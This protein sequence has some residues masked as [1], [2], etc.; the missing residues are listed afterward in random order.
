MSEPCHEKTYDNEQVIRRM[1]SEQKD[2]KIPSE[3]NPR[4]P[5]CGKPMT[6]NLRADDKFVQDDGWYDACARYEEFIETHKNQRVL[7]LELGVG[8]NTPVI[9][10][11]PFWRFTNQNPLA[12]YACINYGEAYCPKQIEK[13]SICI[14]ADIRE[15][16][17]ALG[18]IIK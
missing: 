3:L 8:E 16:L 18:G 13:Q 1:V 7:Y 4:C 12:T 2:R 5:V 15:V 17:L 10:K 14:N 11:Y 9:I 6:M